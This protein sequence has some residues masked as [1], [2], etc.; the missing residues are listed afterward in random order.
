MLSWKTI[1]HSTLQL[2]YITSLTINNA[3]TESGCGY[4]SKV[5]LW[6]IKLY[7]S[8][9]TNTILLYEEDEK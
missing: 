8:I 2:S 1:K 3:D 6:N 9:L 7:C 4:L 5:G